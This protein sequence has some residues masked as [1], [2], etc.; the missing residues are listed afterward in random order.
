MK[1]EFFVLTLP[2][3]LSE[4]QRHLRPYFAQALDLHSIGAWIRIYI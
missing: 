1:K 2:K 4:Q 3:M